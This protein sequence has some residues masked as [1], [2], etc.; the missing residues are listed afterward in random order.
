MAMQ[1]LNQKHWQTLWWLECIYSLQWRTLHWQAVTPEQVLS[2]WAAL[3][4]SCLTGPLPHNS[5]CKVC[6][7]DTA[8]RSVCSNS[9][10]LRSQAHSCGQS[11]H[12]RGSLRPLV[13]VMTEEPLLH[14]IY[15]QF[16]GHFSEDKI[17]VLKVCRSLCKLCW[18]I[19][20][21]R[22]YKHIYVY[23]YM[24]AHT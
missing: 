18:K 2:L 17:T 7:E 1:Q 10:A 22:K 11:M 15:S 23:I 14:K 4:S 6:I 3:T 8:R 19:A 5:W 24:Y 21:L 9:T 16:N 20:A 12:S 13:I